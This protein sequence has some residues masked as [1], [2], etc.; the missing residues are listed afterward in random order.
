MKKL[1]TTAGLLLVL[2][3]TPQS[4]NADPGDPILRGNLD[5][6]VIGQG[7]VTGTGINCPGDCTHQESWRDTEL[8]PNNTLTASTNATGWAFQGW[9]GACT[10]LT[11]PATCR[12]SYGTEESF[13][14]VATFRDVMAPSLYLSWISPADEVGD[15]VSVGAV[16]ND[17]DR[18][19]RVEFLLDGQVLGTANAAPYSA[20]L[21]TS[22]VDEGVHQIQIRAFDPAGNSNV[23]ANWPITIDHTVPALTLNSPVAATN[24]ARPEFSFDSASADFDGAECVIEKPGEGR[25]FDWCGRNEWF[26]GDA[27]TEGEWEFRV[28][29]RDRAGNTSSASHRFIVDRTAPVLGFTGGPDDGATVEKG[30]VEYTWSVED[31]LDVSQKCSIDGGEKTDCDGKFARSLVKGSRTFE[32]EVTDLAGNVSTLSRSV[33][34]K[35]DPDPDPDPDPNGDKVAP[36]VKLSSP[37]QKLKAL[38]KGLKVKVR[39]NEACSGKLVASGARGIRFTGTA[40]LAAAGTRVIRLKPNAK[41]KKVLRASKKTLKLTITSNLADPAG[42]RAGAR[43]KTVIRK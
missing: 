8:P 33:T 25:E 26:A 16:A 27:P 21:D 42:N 40:K 19:T 37:K 6:Q 15:F 11:N 14:S 7:K 1:I 28:I 29:A 13:V 43:L 35:Q 31:G 32:L 22:G 34:V 39:C 38:K 2:L 12:S 30:N 5:V 4:S 41:T 24:A 3:L 23:T 17:N 9:S 20:E 18:V 10:V 36:V